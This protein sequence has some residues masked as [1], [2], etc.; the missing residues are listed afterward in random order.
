MPSVTQLRVTKAK[1]EVKTQKEQEVKNSKDSFYGPEY[2][3]QILRH[4]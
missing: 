1:G 2:Y 3:H 4:N